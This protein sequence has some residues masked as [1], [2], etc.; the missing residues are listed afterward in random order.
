MPRCWLPCP[1]KRKA[2]SPAASPV[3]KHTPP[4][5]VNGSPRCTM[6]RAIS[7]LP[8]RSSSS[9]ATIVSRAAA[10]GRKRRCESHASQRSMPG[11]FASGSSAS[12]SASSAFGSP[13]SV[14]S[15][16]PAEASRGGR[17]PA[18]SSMA[19]WKLLPPK[20]NELTDARR[21]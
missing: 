12:I 3:A 6:G 20:P 9:L 5:A 14:T 19:T 4:G 18:Y 13:L 16:G 10:S 21:G 7:S 17:G 11:C 2:T 1:G 15:S 8:A